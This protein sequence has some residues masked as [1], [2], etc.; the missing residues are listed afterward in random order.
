[1][2]LTDI[3]AQLLTHVPGLS[4]EQQDTAK[5]KGSEAFQFLTGGYQMDLETI[6]ANALS[7]CNN[8]GQIL[9]KDIVFISLCE[10]HLLPSVGKCHIAYVP[11]QQVLGLGK[12]DEI[13]T[14]LSRRLQLQERLTVEI[15]EAIQKATKA[16]GVAV[17]MEAKHLCL[18]LKGIEKC[19]QALIT[20]KFLGSLAQSG[21]EL[22][23]V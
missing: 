13:V 19:Q 16:R 12:F 18:A 3:Y 4:K 5:I 8:A 14:M 10:H 2:N 17:M 21:A 9:I 6:T 22:F 7:P 20:T 1:M 15:A 23:Q 11:E